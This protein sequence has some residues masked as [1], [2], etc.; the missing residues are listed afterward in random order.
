MRA[1]TFDEK[2]DAGE[3]VMPYLD[4]ANVRRPNREPERGS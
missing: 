4:L 3:D 2:F 1:E